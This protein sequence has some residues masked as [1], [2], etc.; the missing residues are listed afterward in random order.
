MPLRPFNREQAWLLPPTLN[1]LIPADH[2]A[3]FIAAFVDGLDAEMWGELEIDLAGDPMGA[4]AYH[5]RALLSIWV[6]GF[7]TG[8]RSSRKLEAACRDQISYMWLAGMQRPDHNTLWRF[9]RA[10]RDQMRAL[11]RRTVR[12]AVKAGLVD[13]ALQA[14]DGT[15][16]A[17]NASRGRTFDAKGLKRLLDRVEAAI[18]D[19]EGQ[20]S[21]GDDPPPASLPEELA[22]AEA[23]RQRVS[24]A[25]GRVEQEE[26]PRYENLT[27]K[28]AGLLSTP[29]GGFIV[30]YNAQSMAAPLNPLA[31]EEADG[32]GSGA[33]MIITAVE[34]TSGPDS[35]PQL[36]PMIEASA[37]NTG[38]SE[39]VVT[40][41]DAGYHSGANLADC[42]S[43]GYQ[44]LMPETHDRKRLSPYHK[45]HF[46]Y[47]TETD[48]YLCPQE[49]VLSYKDTFKHQR[50]YVVRRYRAQGHVCRACPAFGEC[51]KSIHGRTIR[52]SVHEPLLQR[53]TKIMA[54]DSAKDLYRR[55]KALIE[56]VFGLL[57]ECHGARRFLL[58]GRTNVLSEWS[59]LATA[60]NLKSLHRVCRSSLQP[61]SPHM[62][63]RCWARLQHMQPHMGI[64]R[65]RAHCLTTHSRPLSQRPYHFLATTRLQ[66]PPSV[67]IRRPSLN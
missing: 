17:A 33:G 28:D 63:V 50:G 55:R 67:N 13:L 48:T 46:T 21:T 62:S 61:A 65:R 16:I 9:Y 23:L 56:P 7:M 29:N 39:G 64:A 47:R 43:S 45:E 30:G 49:E 40:L 53:H 4:G 2:P 41:A 10:H 8:V 44:V 37:H 52:V 12:T 38:T 54:T 3:R 59:L 15:R 27:D 26:G 14:V 60:F 58:R 35:H 36:V 5:P 6:Y 24:E 18:K 51:T 42:D 32:R 66:P 1:E 20:N 25:L 22:S 19:L 57:K 34:V 31:S 11:M